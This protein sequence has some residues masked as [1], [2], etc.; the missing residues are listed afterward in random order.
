[1]GGVKAFW[2]APLGGDVRD[3]EAELLE[4]SAWRRVYCDGGASS[5]LATVV[6][7][8][9]P[10]ALPEEKRKE[11]GAGGGAREEGRQLGFAG[12][13]LR[14]DLVERKV[15]AGW[16]KRCRGAHALRVVLGVAM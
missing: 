8:G 9:S 14:G 16:L 15:E 12:R 13:R 5:T 2:P 3:G 4:A 11:E 6:H 1:L 10:G 7:G